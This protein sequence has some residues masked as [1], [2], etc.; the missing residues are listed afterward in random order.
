MHKTRKKEFTDCLA[1]SAVFISKIQKKKVFI[2]AVSV[3]LY[4]LKYACSLSLQKT[5]LCLSC[6]PRPAQEWKVQSTAV[7]PGQLPHARLLITIDNMVQV[8]AF[9]FR[10]TL[11]ILCLRP[12]SS[13][14]DVPVIFIH[15]LKTGLF[16][17]KLHGAMGKFSMV[18]PLVDNMVV[19][20]RSLGRFSLVC[21]LI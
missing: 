6:W 14:K 9:W 21:A 16:R 15:P 7:L 13:E 4:I 10:L 1:W 19:S 2:T 12:S 5:F 8:R 17:I 18:I 3:C 20:R 11:S